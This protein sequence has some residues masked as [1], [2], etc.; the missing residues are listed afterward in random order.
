LLK[1]THEIVANLMLGAIALPV[2]AVAWH[3]FVRRDG[4]AGRM[5]PEAPRLP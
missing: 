4:V 1:E 5:T 2:A 3:A